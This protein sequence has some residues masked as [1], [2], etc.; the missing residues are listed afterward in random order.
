LRIFGTTDP[1]V[2][3]LVIVRTSDGVGRQDDTST[4]VGFV[5]ATGLGNTNRIFYLL[6]GASAG[7]E[8]NTAET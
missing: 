7:R 6:Y 4:H 3:K 2:N 1:S 5:Q 8:V